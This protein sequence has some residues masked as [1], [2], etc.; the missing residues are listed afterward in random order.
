MIVIISILEICFYD[1]AVCSLP[2]R[3]KLWRAISGGRE[4]VWR[5]KRNPVGRIYGA[6]GHPHQST[7]PH[8]PAYDFGRAVF[9]KNPFSNGLIKK[10]AKIAMPNTTT[11]RITREVTRK[12]CVKK[13]ISSPL[14][15]NNFQSP[16]EF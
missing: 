12:A 8:M 14:I 3:Q 10:K 15:V 11:E 16:Y 7:C 6:N 9:S 5:L 1:E 2:G 13:S 4:Q